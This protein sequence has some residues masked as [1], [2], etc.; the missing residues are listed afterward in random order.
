LPTVKDYFRDLFH[1]VEVT[2]CDKTI[3][4][5]TGFTMELSQKMNYEQIAAAVAQRLGTEPDLIQFYKPQGYRDGPSGAI[6]CNYDGTL[7]DLLVFYKPR[8]PKKLYYQQLTI[9]IHELENKK[10]FK[11]I[12]VNSKL[13][14]E[15]LQLYPNKSGTVFDLLE[16]A[17]KQIELS[18]DSSGKLRLLELTTNKISLVYQDDVLLE[19]LN[20]SGSK[21][22]RVEEIPKEE[23]KLDLLEFVTP[24]A[25]FQ[26]EIYQTFGTPFL[27]K[28]RNKEPFSSVKERIQK[29]IDVPDKE[30][31]KFKFAIV[32]G[33]RVQYI[34]EENEYL[35]NKDDF[36]GHSI[37]PL[38][39]SP[40]PW[41]GLEHVNKAPK[42]SR[43]NYLEKAIKIHN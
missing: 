14:E 39:G 38:H 32:T 3:S 37:N 34:N 1:R 35:V 27:L 20:P 10:Q 42:R 28:L 13:K 6:K 43:Y 17:K 11:C 8:Q 4:N 23:L 12:W 33:G 7:K 2:F 29:K 25:H 9:K 19:C 18:E 22:Y 30:F 41:L 40:K 31:E 21:V 16:E 15:E 36:M 5:D 26:K 24:V